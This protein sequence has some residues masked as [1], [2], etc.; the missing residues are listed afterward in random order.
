MSWRLRVLHRS[1]FRYV[2]PVVSSYNEARMTP[3]TDS[4]QTALEARVEVSPAAATYRYWDYWGSHVTAFDVQ[5][6]HTE[7][8]VTATSVVE[9]GARPRSGE[10][11]D[12]AALADDAFRD[13]FCEWLIPTPRTRPEEDLADI[14]ELMRSQPDPGSAA[15]AAAQAVRA[16][17]KY[18]PGVTAVHTSAHEA[19]AERKGVCQ[20]IAHVTLA[21]VRS[22]GVPARYVSGYL[23]PSAAAEVGDTVVG[24]SHAWV[25]WWDGCWVAY[26]PTNRID[27]AERHVVVARGRD[28]GDVAPLKGIYSGPASSALGVLVEVTRLA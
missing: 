10:P 11:L 8:A 27:V 12:W 16:G 19:W 17:M 9:T 14:A 23:H 4:A 20:D 18:V 22:L 2:G 13:R 15:L 21:V 7:L 3:L 26:D 24:Q 28:Y 6:P 1:G 5:V 25:E